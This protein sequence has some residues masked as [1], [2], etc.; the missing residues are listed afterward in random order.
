MR[1]CDSLV[2]TSPV[3]ADNLIARCSAPTVAECCTRILSLQ[4]LEITALLEEYHRRPDARW[5]DNLLI[6]MSCLFPHP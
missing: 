5:G 4:P 1:R 2:V 6:A 3:S